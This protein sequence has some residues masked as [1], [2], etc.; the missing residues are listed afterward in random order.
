MFF[1]SFGVCVS[2]AAY[3]GGRALGRKLLR[4]RGA[5]LLEREAEES[6]FALSRVRRAG[7]RLA[8]PLATYAACVL[9]SFAY[10]RSSGETVPSLTVEVL[11]DGPA[12][13]AGMRSGDRIRSIHGA[14]PTSWDEVPRMVSAAPPDTP[15]TVQVQ[16]DSEVL[17]FAVTP[18]ENRRIHIRSKAERRSVSATGTLA[19]AGTWPVRVIAQGLVTLKDTVTSGS[20]TVL[21][22]PVAIVRE[23]EGTTTTPGRFAALLLVLLATGAAYA[24]PFV[25]GIEAMLT[26]RRPR[27]RATPSRGDAR[28][29]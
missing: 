10:I 25:I 17:T 18:D 22:G 2:V 9:L 3:F 26:P 24:W 28:A 19:S 15:L 21:Q 11:P 16:R 20:Q 4:I 12:A 6:Y 14:A 29:S 13:R 1:L 23:V 7:F 5:R 27:N 8:G